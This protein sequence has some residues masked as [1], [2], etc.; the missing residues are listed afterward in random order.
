MYI[1]TMTNI[2]KKKT[3][4]EYLEQKEKNLSLCEIC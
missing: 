4:V 2:S 1:I 3:I